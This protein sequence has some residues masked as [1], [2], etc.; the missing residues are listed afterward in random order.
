MLPSRPDSD[1]AIL[2]LGYVGLTL[3]VAMADVGYRIHG[4]ENNVN[5]LAQLQRGVPHFNEPGLAESFAKHV[6]N[7]AISIHET[8]P[9]H[10]PATVFI[11][12]V[13]T[14][15]NAQKKADITAIQ[16]VSRTILPVLKPDDLVL[17]RSTA[18]IRCAREVVKPILDQAGTSYQLAMC[19]ERTAEGRAL[20]ELRQLPQLV[21]GMDAASTERAAQIFERL[22]PY[23]KRLSNMETAAF[24][25]LINNTLRD[26]LFAFANEVATMAD[27]LGLDAQEVVDAAND[28]YPRS[29]LAKPGLVGGPCMEKDSYI[30]RDSLAEL[31]VTPELI[32]RG[33]TRNESMIA[34]GIARAVTTLATHGHA[35]DSIKKI[36]VLGLAFKGE[37]AV[38]DIR[39][40]L[41]IDLFKQLQA[42]FPA[43]HIVGYDAVASVAEAA[44]WELLAV[45]KLEDTLR[46]ANLVFVQNNHAAFRGE[47]LAPHLAQLAPHA[48]IYDFWGCVATSVMQGRN[49]FYLGLGAKMIEPARLA[50]KAIEEFGLTDSVG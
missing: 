30:L 43:A 29:H 10:C 15:I 25:K 37:P 8:L 48:L 47:A 41:A 14:P 32:M 7:G 39:G 28:R 3:A 44:Q 27:A 12:T 49:L 21:G 46:D 13:G 2:G 24:V 23:V 19:P 26:V 34:Y 4:I 31:A 16:A 35:A 18:T 17:L 9:R 40:S 36:A 11:I 42:Q 45:P 20:E 6:Q 33:R 50:A 5:T 1:I 38:Q 22:T